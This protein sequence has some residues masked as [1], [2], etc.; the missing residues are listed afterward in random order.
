M[1]LHKVDEKLYF[2]MPLRLFGRE[3]L[4]SS[5]VSKTSNNMAAVVGIPR[6]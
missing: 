1:T 6:T 2:E 3:M 5:S 4:L